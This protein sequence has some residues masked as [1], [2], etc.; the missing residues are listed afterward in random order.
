MLVILTVTA[1]WNYNWAYNT[2]F[3]DAS[4]RMKPCHS[5][6]CYFRC[7]KGEV[8]T[9]YF[10][11]RQYEIVWYLNCHHIFSANANLFQHP[12][13][14]IQL[15]AYCQCWILIFYCQIFSNLFYIYVRTSCMP[16]HYCSIW[17]MLQ[18][19]ERAVLKNG[20]RYYY[21]RLELCF[22]PFS[23]KFSV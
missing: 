22:C 7:K 10:S 15:Q 19:L 2:G 17:H 1:G 20:K 18:L 6:A 11:F 8:Y 9:D 21:S 14:W 5:K 12:Q 13:D 16:I 3:R 23:D 4:S